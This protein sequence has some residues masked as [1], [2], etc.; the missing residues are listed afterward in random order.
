M[1]KNLLFVIPGL[2]AGGGEK[3]LVNLLGQID[4][5]KYNVDLFLFNHDGIFMEHLPDNVRILPLPEAYETFSKPLQKSIITFLMRGELKSAFNRTAY[6]V[7]NRLSSN[8]SISEQRSW[9]YLSKTI[10]LIGGNYDVAIGFLEKT[11]TYFCVDNIKANKK[12][13]WVHIDYNKMGMNKK[14]DEIYF[15][16]LQ[17]IVTVSEECANI[18]KKTFPEQKSKVGVIYNIVSPM[19]INSMANQKKENVFP[20]A[21]GETVILSIG[22]LH[23]QKGFDL[24]IKACKVLIDKGYNVKWYIIGEGSERNSLERLIKQNNLE[25]HFILLGLKSNPY[26]YIEQADIYAQTSLFEGKAIAIDEAKILAKP[27]LVTNFST[28]SDQ[29]NNEE[30]GLIVD[31]NAGCVANGLE[32]MMNNRDLVQSYSTNLKQQHLGTESEIEKLYNLINN[33]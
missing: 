21:S 4:Y 19:F 10:G 24:A 30:N 25:K 5:T 32:K 2:S 3:S 8:H 7:V 17:S 12:I 11:S 16:N 1:K 23:Y 18:L 27:I 15:N 20:E 33:G 9:K 14:M 31:I 13:G 26:P 6:S 28:A 22:R 29:I